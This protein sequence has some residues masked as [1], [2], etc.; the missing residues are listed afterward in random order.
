MYPNL[1]Y[2]LKELLGVEWSWL[3]LFNTFGFC[4]ALDFLA[5]AWILSIELKRKQID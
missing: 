4:V 1:Y 5:A 3:K 2:A